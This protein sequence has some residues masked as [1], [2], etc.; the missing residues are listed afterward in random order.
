MKTE[1]QLTA[2]LR[3]CATEN[4]KTGWLFKISILALALIMSSQHFVQSQS[5][6]TLVGEPL[7]NYGFA[8]WNSDI[9]P[10]LNFDVSE[11]H[12]GSHRLDGAVTLPNG[13][14]YHKFTFDDGSYKTYTTIK[15]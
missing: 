6:L 9:E 4:R 1:R 7:T 3:N 8:I 14:L 11:G 13:F 15:Q 5:S 12:S 2:Q 10:D